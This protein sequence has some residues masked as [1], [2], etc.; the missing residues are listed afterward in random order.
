MGGTRLRIGGAPAPAG[1][2]FCSADEPH[3]RSIEIF[4]DAAA[5]RYR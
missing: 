2:D 4:G 5:P 3:W 1:P